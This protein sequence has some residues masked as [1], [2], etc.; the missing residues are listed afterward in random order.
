LLRPGGR[1]AVADVVADAPVDEALRDDLAA[2]TDCVAGAVTR[3]EY[4]SMLAAAGFVQ[5]TI[6]D[7]HVV[8]DGFTSVLVRAV[9]ASP[10]V[11]G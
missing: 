3:D 10:A 1:L 11:D 7:S 2:W 5:I 4:R 9:A 6:D 8:A